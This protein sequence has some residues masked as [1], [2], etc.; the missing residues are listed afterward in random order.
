MAKLSVK[1]KVS[2][3]EE[4]GKNKKMC[5]DHAPDSDVFGSEETH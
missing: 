2:F 5:V 4:G 3:S 1:L